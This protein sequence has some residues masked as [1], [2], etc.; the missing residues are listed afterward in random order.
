MQPTD[1][2]PQ[3]A[4]KIQMSINQISSLSPQPSIKSKCTTPLK[5]NQIAL[6]QVMQLMSAEVQWKSTSMFC[7]KS[8][9][10][11]DQ[12]VL[13][14]SSWQLEAKQQEKLMKYQD[15]LFKLK[16]KNSKLYMKW[17]SRDNQ[18]G[19]IRAVQHQKS[20]RQPTRNQ[21]SFIN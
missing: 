8:M 10:N 13:H 1:T 20:H 2:A 15:Y 7:K 17:Q 19:K 9:D 11:K 21:S 18:P 3:T 14:I 5:Y 6:L 4:I 16:D 12:H